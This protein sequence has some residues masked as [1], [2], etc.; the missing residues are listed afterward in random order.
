MSLAIRP[1]TPADA[2]AIRDIYAPYV[3]DTSITFETEVPTTAEIQQRLHS[4]LERYPWIVCVE[5]ET[6]VGYAYA[7]M[8]NKRAAYQ[9]SVETSVYIVQA[10]HGRGIG[11]TLYTILFALLYAQRIVNAYAGITMPN[12]ASIA[13]H[14]SLGFQH[15]GTFTGAGFKHGAWHDVDWWELP[16]SIRSPDAIPPTPFAEMPPATVQSITEE[17]AALL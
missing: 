14:K 10:H 2:A 7:G 17:G 11:R 1:A 6:I 16:L 4:T 8:L 9:W 13:L 15:A 5:A 3:T 12:P